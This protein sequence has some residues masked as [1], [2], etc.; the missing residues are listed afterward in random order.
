[1]EKLADN[2]YEKEMTQ[3][4]CLGQGCYCTIGSTRESHQKKYHKNQTEYFL[5]VLP[6]SEICPYCDQILMKYVYPKY[7]L[8]IRFSCDNDKCNHKKKYNS[9]FHRY[10]FLGTKTKYF[11]EDHN[12][13]GDKKCP[14]CIENIELNKEVQKMFARIF[15]Q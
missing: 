15:S 14:R 13:N 8:F 3:W 5:A 9:K 11:C 4:Y 12:Y 7:P 1:M 6:N 2:W 10:E